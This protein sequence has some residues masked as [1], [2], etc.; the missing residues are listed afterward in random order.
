MQQFGT[1]LM[2]QIQVRNNHIMRESIY[3]TASFSASLGEHKFAQYLIGDY[4][5]K[6]SS[7]LITLWPYLSEL[8]WCHTI[9]CFEDALLQFITVAGN[10]VAG[11][12]FIVNLDTHIHRY[13][14]KFSCL[15]I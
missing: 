8:V 2:A 1:L 15:F 14:L 6:R 9:G 10:N 3:S 4:L 11:C 13:E 12:L 5:P 7:Y